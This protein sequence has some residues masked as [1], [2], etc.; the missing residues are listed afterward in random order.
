MNTIFTFIYISFQYLENYDTVELMQSDIRHKFMVP[1]LTKI[2]NEYS[3][4]L[5]NPTR[6]HGNL[7]CQIRQVP[8]YIFIPHHNHDTSAFKYVVVCSFVNSINFPK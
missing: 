1:M 7:V 3:N 2:K 5:H 8:L 6:F 4:I